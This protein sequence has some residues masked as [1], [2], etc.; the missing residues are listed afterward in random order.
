MILLG[1]LNVLGIR[2]LPNNIYSSASPCDI[3]WYVS[4]Q[5][6]ILQTTELILNSAGPETWD[7][8]SNVTQS[9]DKIPSPDLYLGFSVQN[10]MHQKLAR[11]RDNQSSKNFS[12]SILKQ[13]TV[14]GLR[15]VPVAKSLTSIAEMKSDN[16]EQNIPLLCFPWCILQL[17]Q[18]EG[19]ARADENDDTLLKTTLEGS[20][21]ATISLSM[22]EKLSRFADVKQNGQHIPPVITITSVGSNTTV[23]LAYSEIV[24]EKYRDH[25]RASMEDPCK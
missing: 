7:T 21:A 22:F 12:A 18:A 6:L 15:S 19:L 3:G 23:W 13:L 9:S 4:Y 11:F 20:S 14:N 10:A 2:G 24:D 17:K 8:D 16:T 1:R 25:V 5:I